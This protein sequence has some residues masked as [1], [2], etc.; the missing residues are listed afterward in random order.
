M[1]SAVFTTTASSMATRLAEATWDSGRATSKD[2]DATWM[3]SAQSVTVTLK[4]AV[5]LKTFVVTIGEPEKLEDTSHYNDTTT[6]VLVLT[7]S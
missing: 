7:T 3:G 6:G 5:R 1:R 4:D 2:A